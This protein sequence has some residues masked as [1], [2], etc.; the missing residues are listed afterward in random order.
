VSWAPFEYISLLTSIVLAL[1]ISRTLTGLGKLLQSRGRPRAYWV[2]GAWGMN[3]LLWLL[4]NWWILFR[5]HT[6]ERWTFFYSSLC[7]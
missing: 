1:G 7:S 4:L 2:H 3:V 5:W 6:Q